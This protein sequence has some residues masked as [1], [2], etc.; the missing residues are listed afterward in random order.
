[1]IKQW[2]FRVGFQKLHVMNVMLIKNKLT[3]KS[4]FY[5]IPFYMIPRYRNRKKKKICAVRSL[6]SGY[7]WS[8]Q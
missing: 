6:D 3:Q 5:R 2:H 8:K 1:M 7:S 4:T